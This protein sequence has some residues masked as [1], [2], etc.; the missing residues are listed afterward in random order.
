MEVTIYHNPRCS[1]SREALAALKENDS[2]T[3][4]VREY[5]KEPL[6]AEELTLLLQ[7]LNMNA[8]ELLRK[9]ESIFKEEYKNL[10][11][12]NQE[13][14][15]VMVSHPKLIERPIVEVENRAVVARPKEKIEEI[16]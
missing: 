10:D 12:T 9:G 8:A 6:T 2:V 1:K 14:I 16:L 7:K 13:W 4:Q 5:L 11:L 15:Q 3:L